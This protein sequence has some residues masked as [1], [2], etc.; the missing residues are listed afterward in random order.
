MSYASQ[1]KCVGPL[2]AT[3]FFEKYNTSDPHTSIE[4]CAHL[5]QKLCAVPSYVTSETTC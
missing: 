1:V 3:K 4:N 2:Y 5:F